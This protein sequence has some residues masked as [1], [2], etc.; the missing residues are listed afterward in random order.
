MQFE[1]IPIAEA[2]VT[3][4]MKSINRVV[5][6]PI[7]FFLF[8]LALVYFLYGLVQY[9][10]SPDNEEVRKSSKSHMIW[11][12]LG[13]FIMVAVFG[14]MN[15]ILTTIGETKIKINNN[16]DYT[17]DRVELNSDGSQ[18]VVGTDSFLST[19]ESKRSINQGQIGNPDDPTKTT[20]TGLQNSS[21]ALVNQDKNFDPTKSPFPDYIIN[22]SVCWRKVVNFSANTEYEATHPKDAKNQEYTNLQ[23]YARSIFL[24]DTG[25]KDKDVS[26][27]LPTSYGYEALVKNTGTKEKPIYKYY[28]WGDYRAP[29][30]GSSQSNCNLKINPDQS[31]LNYTYLDSYKSS[32]LNVSNS[33]SSDKKLDPTKSPFPVYIEKKSVCWRDTTS[34]KGDTENE[35]TSLVY[36]RK[37]Y[38]N[39]QSYFRDVYLDWIGKADKD[40]SPNLPVNYGYEALYNSAD[41][42]YYV[43]VD[44]R[45]PVGNGTMADCSLKLSLDQISD[46]YKYA[47]AYLSSNINISN[48]QTS[49]TLDFTKS[50]F[51]EY[52][53]NATCW[54]KELLLKDKTEYKAL[55][56]VDIEARKVY[57]SSTGQIDSEA[58]KF[59]PKKYGMQT[60]LN[61]ADQN[62]YVWV[63]LRAPIGVNGNCNLIAKQI[64][65]KPDFRSTKASSLIGSVS[66]DILYYRVVD[67]GVASTLGEARS[68]AINNALIQIAIQKGVDNIMIIPYRVIP[69]ERYF[70]QDSATG[71]YDYFVAIESAK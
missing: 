52:L 29:K 63:D 71:N 13:L 24:S 1:I 8:A 22:D 6:N 50:P 11:G 45:A 53:P 37:S 44:Y 18:A 25:Q 10:I 4:L 57:L 38:S 9:L 32:N 41:K 65:P 40:V 30:K 51:P 28:V 55:Q 20:T 59:L 19:P 67:S 68:I 54:R 21:N 33:I 7:I 42:K 16:G 14:I 66:N 48:G 43:W 58:D 3:T 39:L 56:N 69:P 34:F 60:A 61:P 64:L 2:S 23:N 31:S 47:N 15:L 46:N 49:K 27:G 36:K 5:L 17:V 62:Y 70:P 12:I 35:A 26:I